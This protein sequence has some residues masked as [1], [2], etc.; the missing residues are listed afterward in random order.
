MEITKYKL[1]DVV[2]YL[3]LKE[4]GKD[5]IAGILRSSMLEP[6]NIEPDQIIK[7]YQNGTLTVID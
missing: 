5:V 6:F 4:Q 1:K 2:R 3:E 7:A